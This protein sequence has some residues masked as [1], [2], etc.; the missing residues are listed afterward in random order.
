MSWP[1]LSLI[2]GGVMLGVAV[3]SRPY[4]F[5]NIVL[6]LLAIINIAGG[7]QKTENIIRRRA[8]T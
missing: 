6:F 8:K 1:K 4:D 5:D 3:A 2:L 7:W